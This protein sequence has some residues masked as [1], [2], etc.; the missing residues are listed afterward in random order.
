MP[1]SSW[2]GFLAS[3]RGG[4]FPAA[5]EECISQMATQVARTSTTWAD[6][7][8]SVTDKMV[9][10]SQELR[11]TL[12][13]MYRR[14]GYTGAL[15]CAFYTGGW[16]M[17]WTDGDWYKDFLCPEESGHRWCSGH[18][19]LGGNEA[20][21]VR[22]EQG[23]HEVP[24]RAM[25]CALCQH[26][27]GR[28]GPAP[29]NL[30]AAPIPSPAHAADRY[31]GMAQAWEDALGGKGYWDR[32]PGWDMHGFGVWY[33][34]TLWPQ[35]LDDAKL[36]TT[37]KKIA[38]HRL[39]NGEVL[40]G[41]V[42]ASLALLRSQASPLDPSAWAARACETTRIFYGGG[43]GGENDEVN[44][45]TCAHG[46]G[47][48]LLYHYGSI[49]SALPA[50]VRDATLREWGE[51]WSEGC[52]SG[53]YHSAFNSL[54]AT[55]L[56]EMARRGVDEVTRELCAASAWR[57]CPARDFLGAAE[58]EGR[59]AL[60][61]AGWCKG[62]QSRTVSPPPASSPPP[63]P[64]PPSP[65]PPPDPAPPPSPLPPTPQPPPPPPPPSPLPSPPP[66]DLFLGS[67][68]P[69]TAAR[70]DLPTG[71]AHATAQQQQQPMPHDL[72]EWRPAQDASA[73]LSPN[74]PISATA[75]VG[76][77]HTAAAGAGAEDEGGVLGALAASAPMIFFVVVAAAAA[78]C[79][80]CV[81]RG[82][83]RCRAASASAV[84]PASELLTLRDEIAAARKSDGSK[85]SS[86]PSCSRGKP[87]KLPGR[88]GGGGGP[89]QGYYQSAC[90]V[91]TGEE[92]DCYR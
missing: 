86:G 14:H 57:E 24:I 26:L 73:V 33:A 27:K 51:G 72:Y 43:G 56:S 74:T 66:L 31:K 71:W 18:D 84:A 50:C 6:H 23:G 3:P 10:Q 15:W 39:T 21:G 16:P 12:T 9:F 4:E 78:A 77:A 55:Q 59:L 68:L 13:P 42:W 79:L 60:V 92:E 25:S 45:G 61:R 19:E 91:C 1:A 70:L 44:F 76:P 87:G 53:V 67:G 81:C 29:F 17:G 40:H 7:C 41:F 11:D 63:P 28:F 47:H 58:A 49:E 46:S 83:R 69:E 82:L 62:W 5:L 64:P 65:P 75:L 90:T 80:A 89:K 22:T 36:A 37:I 85:R 54:S 32:W 38:T 48:G 52:G 20:E 8:E 88:L 35:Q 30:Q 34:E 2:L